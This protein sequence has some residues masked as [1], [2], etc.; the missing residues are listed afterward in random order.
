M[1][2]GGRAGAGT[3]PAGRTGATVW[4][5]GLP[6]AGKSTIA[7]AV[8]GR[9]LASGRE[10]EI[11]D[12]DEVRTN[13]SAGLG[14]SKEDRDTNV[15]RVGYVARLLAAHGVLVLVPVIAPY[16]FSREAVRLLHDDKGVR[17]LEVHI[18]TAVDV[19]A[20][21]DVKGLYAEYASGRLSGLTGID[22]V[23]EPPVRPDLRLDT[24]GEAVAESADR[25]MRLLREQGLVRGQC[26]QPRG[27]RPLPA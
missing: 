4:L 5:T 13:L 16:E 21:R 17:Y 18:A 10:V 12:G 19:C 9:L 6:S 23:Y 25:L 7:Q 15:R 8:A 27:D 24:A 20:M 2:D 11:L 22:D 26:P 3:G 14:F 1:R